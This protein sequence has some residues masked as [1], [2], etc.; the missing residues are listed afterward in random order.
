MPV[1]D[2]RKRKY[3]LYFGLC[4]LLNSIWA[5][6]CN[7]PEIK[8]ERKKIDY[9]R[10]IPGENDTIPVAVAQ[11]GEVLIA[12][13]DC[14]TCHKEDKKSVGPA[15]KDIAKRYP[16]QRVYIEMLAQR[17]MSGGSGSWGRAVMSAHPKVSNEE[18]K[19]MVSYILSLKEVP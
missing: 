3:H 16:V 1:D 2:Q 4:L 6:A 12:Y 10:A 9:I 14:Y 11:K 5:V 19:I 17:V 13:S 18:A 8:N 7:K 15:F